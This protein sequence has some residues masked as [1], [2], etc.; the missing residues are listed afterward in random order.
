MKI[1]EE[2]KYE[3]ND[4]L[5]YWAKQTVDDEFGGFLGRIDHNNNLIK[6]SPKGSVLN[7]RILWMFSAAYG[8]NNNVLYKQL[9]E[10]AFIYLKSNFFDKEFG[11]IYWMLDH[12]GNPIDTKKQTYALS[13]AIYGMAEFYK[14]SKN[15]EALD[16]AIHLFNDLEKHAFDKNLGGYFEAFSR[17]WEEIADLRLS[18]KDANEKK[19]MNTHLHVLEAY[20][21]LYTIWKN[22]VLEKQIRSLLNDFRI[23][24]I[25]AETKHL[26][27]FMNEK[28]QYK[29]HIYSFGHDI[30]AAWLLLEAAEALDDKELINDF[31]TISVELVNAASEGLDEDGSLFYEQDLDKEHLIKEKH[32]WVQAE[33]M[34]GFLNAWQLTK[35]PEYYQKFEKVWTYIKHQI[36]DHNNGE[37]FWGRYGDENL[38]ENE[39][40]VGPWKCPYHNVRACL[41]SIKRLY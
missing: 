17:E 1:V 8:Y 38:M 13:F 10:R 2:L 18:D 31:K 32:W 35:E 40:K 29:Q 30:E 11:G 15:E 14:V 21:N 6:N 7:S 36:I 4:I 37:W 25:D 19:T 9:A 26:I 5:N 33:A 39:D 41:E 28:W 27:L 22:S 24:I 16:L 20:S 34:V 3:L 12:Q 23:H